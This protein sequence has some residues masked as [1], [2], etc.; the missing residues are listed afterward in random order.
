VFTSYGHYLR[1]YRIWAD[2]RAAFGRIKNQVEALRWT[3]YTYREEQKPLLAVPIYEDLLTRDTAKT[4]NW[5]M[6]LAQ[7]YHHGGKYKEAIAAYQQADNPPSNLQQIAECYR[8]MQQYKEAIGM[9]SQIVGAY[10]G[11]PAQWALLQLAYTQ[12]QAG[13]TEAAIKTFQQVCKRYPN[14]NEGSR[15]HTHL[16]DKYKITVT[17]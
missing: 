11:G 15:A 13:Q 4:A 2:A 1:S 16:F 8:A 6:E 9:Y 12:E 3:A 7:A 17:K 14:S 5:Q 10:E